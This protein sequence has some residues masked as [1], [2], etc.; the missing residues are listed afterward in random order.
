M[1][2]SMT[3]FGAAA[4]LDGAFSVRVEARSVNHRF[5]QVKTRLP[6]SSRTWKAS[7]RAS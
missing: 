5:L 7:S 2:R 4:V 1:I 3:G 6:S